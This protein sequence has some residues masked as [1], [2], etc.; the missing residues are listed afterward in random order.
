[1]EVSFEMERTKPM[2]SSSG[3]S[4]REA[5]MSA[6]T[7]APALINGLRGF[8]NSSSSCTSEL[9]YAPDGSLPILFHTLSPSRLKAMA[10]ENTFD[11]L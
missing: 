9:N 5:R 11:M 10:S 8:P 6:T 2:K 7:I 4:R 1:M 3:F